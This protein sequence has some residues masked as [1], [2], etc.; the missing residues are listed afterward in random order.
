VNVLVFCRRSLP[1]ALALTAVALV[2]ASPV[3]AAP[4]L[5]PSA[6]TVV[7]RPLVVGAMQIRWITFTNR[8]A[9]PVT[10]GP[11][12][13]YAV[14]TPAFAL[15]R[16]TCGSEIVALAPGTSCAYG[17]A[18][19]PKVQGRFRARLVYAVDG[20]QLASVELRGRTG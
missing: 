6:R 4:G 5:E 15:Y 11:V 8:A 9:G 2:L 14:G 19:T 10:F 17:V 18:F 1:T 16:D 13:V 7:Y 12:A 3:A 20:G